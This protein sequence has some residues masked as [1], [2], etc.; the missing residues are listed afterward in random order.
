[1]VERERRRAA[2]LLLKRMID[3]GRTRLGEVGKKKIEDR[4]VPIDWRTTLGKGKGCA[5]GG[6]EGG[7][8][9]H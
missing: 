5:E 1:V 6:V 3:E 7:M 2:T 8:G 4:Y 9:L